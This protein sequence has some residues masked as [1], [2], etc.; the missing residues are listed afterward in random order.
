[1][2]TAGRYVVVIAKEWEQRRFAAA[3]GFTDSLPE[4]C[5]EAHVYGSP[6]SPCAVYDT[7]LRNWK[8]EPICV[9]ETHG[10]SGARDWTLTVVVSK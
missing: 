9:H 3:L 1:M 4:A 10:W 8:Q 5:A 7:D 6:A 2:K